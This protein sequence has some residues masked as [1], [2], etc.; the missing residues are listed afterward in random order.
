M[1]FRETRERE[2]RN[3]NRNL[4]Y[5]ELM[6]EYP[7]NA[8]QILITT[9]TL[10]RLLLGDPLDP[11]KDPT[12]F[13]LQCIADFAGYIEEIFNSLGMSEPTVPAPAEVVE[14]PVQPST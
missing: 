12:A 3:L 6:E 2:D 7:A 11:E 4:L 9:H 14:F 5:V 13:E 1:E 8:L 10:V